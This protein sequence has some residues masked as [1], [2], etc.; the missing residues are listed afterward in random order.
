MSLPS[1]LISEVSIKA[2][3]DVVWRALRDPAEIRNWFGWQYDGLTDEIV[4]IFIDGPEES[5]ADRRLRWEHGDEFVVESDGDFTTVKAI[6]HGEFDPADWAEI[7]DGWISFL[8]QLRVALEFHLGEERRTIHLKSDKA[9]ALALLLSSS[10]GTVVDLKP[11]TGV[12][13]SGE[14]QFCDGRQACVRVDAYG[15]G[16][17]VLSPAHVIVTTYGLS[18]DDFA[19]VEADWQ[20]AYA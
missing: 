7:D 13:V 10:P 16:L 11:A 14:L 9:D 18:D 5:A 1:T 15:N 3:A 17:V 20:A 4:E 6:R 8:Q 2:D 19:A 12:E